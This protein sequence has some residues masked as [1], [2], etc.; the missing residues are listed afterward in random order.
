M[1][2]ITRRMR[3]TVLARGQAHRLDTDWVWGAAVPLEV[4]LGIHTGGGE[5]HWW[6]LS[7]DFLAE[8]LDVALGEG[9]VHIRQHWGDDKLRELT[10]SSPNGI[11]SLLIQRTALHA[12]LATTWSYAAPEDPLP[13]SCEHCALVDPTVFPAVIDFRALALC[14]DCLERA[15]VEVER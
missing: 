5:P 2:V 11:A 15:A 10:L 13:H 14:P 1:K 6:T 4:Q 12:Y 7:R 8:G 9:D 3:L